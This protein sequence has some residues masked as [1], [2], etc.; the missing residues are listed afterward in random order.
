MTS[1]LNRAAALSMP[2]KTSTMPDSGGDDESGETCK[3]TITTEQVEE[4][5]E[6]G[7]VTLQADS[8]ESVELTMDPGEAAPGGEENLG[9]K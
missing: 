3:A 9:A 7:S 8:G 6:K 5:A 4:L 2:A 1:T